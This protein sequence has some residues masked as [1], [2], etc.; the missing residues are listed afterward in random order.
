MISSLRQSP[1]VRYRYSPDPPGESTYIATNTRTR[2]YTKPADVKYAVIT[3]RVMANNTT[4]VCYY[5]YGITDSQYF[6]QSGYNGNGGQKDY[7]QYTGS[8]RTIVI[9]EQSDGLYIWL[10]SGSG[11]DNGR[12]SYKVEE[13]L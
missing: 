3:F 12:W 8:E 1:V 11:W 13:Y 4:T 7:G 9:P 10:A 5:Y 6:A 2:I